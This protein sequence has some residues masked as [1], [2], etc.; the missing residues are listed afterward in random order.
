MN[1]SV[2]GLKNTIGTTRSVIVLRGQH[3][4][5]QNALNK[6]SG[7]ILEY[8]GSGRVQ[9]KDKLFFLSKRRSDDVWKGLN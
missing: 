2:L 9:D 4:K 1:D 8:C 5:M 7:K 6:T 3:S